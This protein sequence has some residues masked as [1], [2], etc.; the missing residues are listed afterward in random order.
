MWCWKEDETQIGRHRDSELIDGMWIQY[1][2]VDQERLCDLHRD[3]EAG[4]ATTTTKVR[5]L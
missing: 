2:D 4:V 5:I 3:V 1:S